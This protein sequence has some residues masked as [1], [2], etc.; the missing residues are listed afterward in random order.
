MMKKNGLEKVQRYLVT[1]QANSVFLG[2]FFFALGSRNSEGAC[3]IS[4]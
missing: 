4:K 1:S 2:R 3:G